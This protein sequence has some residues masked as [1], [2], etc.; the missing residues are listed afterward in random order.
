MCPKNDLQIQKNSVETDFLSFQLN[1]SLNTFLTEDVSNNLGS[2]K[3]SDLLI[4]E[5]RMALNWVFNIWV[6]ILM[7]LLWGLCIQRYIICAVTITQLSSVA[8][9]LE[10]HS[11][12]KILT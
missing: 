2:N 4:L 5:W 3:P 10:M 7:Y 1:H 11:M 8:I 9:I 6:K 12:S